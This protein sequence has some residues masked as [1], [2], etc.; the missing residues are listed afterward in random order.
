[1]RLLA[2]LARLRSN[3]VRQS[4]NWAAPASGSQSPKTPANK[5]ANTQPTPTPAPTNIAPIKPIKPISTTPPAKNGG[6]LGIQGLNGQS[7]PWSIVIMLTALTLI[8][9]LLLCIT[10]FARLLIVFHFLRQALGLQTTP[11]NQTLIGLSMILDILPD[12]SGGKRDFQ[13]GGCTHAV[14][15][16]HS[17]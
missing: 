15:T 9:S 11:S 6:G 4:R 2:Y 8:P 5:P 1:M 3:W 10:P 16:D 17:G 12:A 13:N 7:V 14:G